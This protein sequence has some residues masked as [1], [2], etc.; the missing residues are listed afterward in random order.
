MKVDVSEQASILGGKRIAVFP[1]DYLDAGFDLDTFIADSK[2]Q[3]DPTW[4]ELFEWAMYQE[5]EEI[6]HIS[7]DFVAGST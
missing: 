5:P 6:E 1:K 3:P 4:Y 7:A 2:A